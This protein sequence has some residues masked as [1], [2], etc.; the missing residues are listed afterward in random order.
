MGA[1]DSPVRHR[2][3]NDRLQWLV[4]TASHGQMAHQTV[5]NHCPVRTRQSG[6]LSGV[7]LKFNSQTLRSRV[8]ARDKD[9][10][11]ANLAPPDRGRT[12][13]SGAPH[14]EPL[15]SIFRCFSNRFS[16]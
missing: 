12:G 9:L 13:Q 3:A 10:P 11:R 16:F 4:L 15:I 8:S 2:C 1:P 14:T 6:A 7:P 5:N